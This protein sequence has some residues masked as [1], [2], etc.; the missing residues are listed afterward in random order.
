MSD[1]VLISFINLTRGLSERRLRT[2]EGVTGPRLSLGHGRAQFRLIRQ[3]VATLLLLRGVNI[4]GRC[5][6]TRV[7]LVIV[8][9]RLD[10]E[11]R[12]GVLHSVI[13]VLG[14]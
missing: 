5:I 7:S 13:R 14:W 12:V 3:V 11:R 4:R 2:V 9:A 6:I 10:G 1:K 8:L